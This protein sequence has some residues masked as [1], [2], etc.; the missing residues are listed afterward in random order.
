M[1]KIKR[2]LLCVFAILFILSGFGVTSADSRWYEDYTTEHGTKLTRDFTFGLKSDF[3]AAPSDDVFENFKFFRSELPE[4]LPV[5]APYNAGEIDNSRIKLYVSTDGKD[6]NPGTFDKPFKTIARAVEYA[7]RLEDKSGGLTIYLREGTYSVLDG[8]NI[9]LE[10]S[11]TEENPTF[12]SSYNNENVVITTAVAIN[13]SDME[14]AK[15][16]VADAKLQD[17]VKDKVYSID[18]KKLGYEDYRNFATC[19][20]C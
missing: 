7:K 11:G 5:F 14:I 3:A 10:L 15:D 13:G 20:V 4:E 1:I 18:L 6:N 16:S 19:A 17:S 9:P 12:I 8:I 2:V